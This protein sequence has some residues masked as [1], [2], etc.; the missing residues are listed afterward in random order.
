MR[1]LLTGLQL[2]LCYLALA[3]SVG[4]LRSTKFN[5]LESIVV[6]TFFA[7]LLLFTV[8][9]SKAAPHTRLN[10]VRYKRIMGAAVLVLLALGAGAIAHGVMIGSWRGPPRISAIHQLSVEFANPWALAL[11][12]ALLAAL[13]VGLALRL[14]KP[15]V[16]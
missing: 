12:F 4:M 15:A 13:L 11:A 1:F 3:I 9:V 16:E 14:L 2:V 10:Q 6:A 5:W 7:G 8:L